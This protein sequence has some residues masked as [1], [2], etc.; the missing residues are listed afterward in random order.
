MNMRSR[1]RYLWFAATVLNA[2]SVM[3]LFAQSQGP[4]QFNTLVNEAWEAVNAG[5]Y[6]PSFGGVKWAAVR[7]E[8]VSANYGSR[9]EAYAAIRQMLKRLNNPAT[10]FLTKEQ[11]PAFLDEIGGRPHI[12]TG[13]LELLVVDVEEESRKLQIVTTIPNTPARRAGLQ[14]GDRLLAIDGVQTDGLGLTEAM[15][16]LRGPKGTTARLAIQRSGKRFEVRVVH[17]E[18]PAIESSVHRETRQWRGQ[19]IGYVR[20]DLF[21]DTSV[22]QVREA[23]RKLEEERVSGLLLDLRNNPGG[24]VRSCL[25]IAGLF[26]GEAPLVNLNGREGLKPLRASGE[27]VTKLPLNVLV[28]KG[29]ASAGELLAAALQSNQ[30]GAIVG[31]TTY[32]K[33]LVHRAAQLS[34]GSMV[35]ITSGS[36]QTLNGVEILGR[37]ITPDVSVRSTTG[38]DEQWNKAADL[39]LRQRMNLS[40]TLNERRFTS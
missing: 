31:Q 7:Q 3:A 33:G 14:P 27:Q 1:R 39:L 25:Q 32:G 40:S 23:V 17:Q 15:E 29:T 34:D 26:L 38:R 12:G 18:L 6:D 4:S 30:R 16:K 28:N 13:L 24:D 8:F 9:E 10:R 11:V 22:E 5:Y 2:L 37:G 19:R 21:L 35:L 20:L 36:L